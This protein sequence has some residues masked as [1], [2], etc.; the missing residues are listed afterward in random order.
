MT[1]PLPDVVIEREYL[2]R[3]REAHLM[4]VD[5]IEKQLDMPRTSE[6]RAEE[7]RLKNEQSRSN[8]SERDNISA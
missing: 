3:L 7:R 2:M 4:I 5:A 6:L 1:F 8:I